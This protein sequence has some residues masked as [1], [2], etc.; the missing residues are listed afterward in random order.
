VL[1]Q[2]REILGRLWLLRGNGE[3]A[4]TQFRQVQQSGSAAG[5]E[6]LAR[7]RGPQPGGLETR[8]V[9]DCGVVERTLTEQALEA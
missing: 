5:S 3:R 6:T 8:R 7:A 1:L 2:G 9:H 4:A